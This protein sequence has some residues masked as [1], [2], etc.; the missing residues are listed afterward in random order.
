MKK[1][2]LFAVFA[3]II[4]SLTGCGSEEIKTV[5]YYKTHIAERDAKIKECLNNPEASKENANC[6]NAGSAKF[7]SGVEIDPNTATN[8]KQFDKF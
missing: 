2:I 6:T 5:E 1:S 8:A 7:H 4:L 3:V